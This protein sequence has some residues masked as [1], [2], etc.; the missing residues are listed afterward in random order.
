[1]GRQVY[2]L[3]AD[4]V[5]SRPGGDEVL[6]RGDVFRPTDAE[7]R[8]FG[9]LLEPVHLDPAQQ[10]TVVHALAAG[11]DPDLSAFAVVSAE[12]DAIVG[13][14]YDLTVDQV[15]A[16]VEAG[17]V[18]LAAAYVAEQLG[19]ARHTLLAELERMAGEGAGGDA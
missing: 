3:R 19:R 15:L 1:M 12:S 2:R 5:R 7:L 4:L 17:E 11:E 9:D 8:A 13:E 10:A 14:V 18:G 6:R 16:R